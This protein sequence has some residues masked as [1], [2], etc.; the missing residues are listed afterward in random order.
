MD[1]AA[2]EQLAK[3]LSAMSLREAQ[4]ELRQLDPEAEMKFWRNAVRNEQHTLWVL[5]Q[6]GVAVTLVERESLSPSDRE[7]GGGPRGTKAQRTSYEYV[8]AR[9]APLTRPPHKRG[10]HGPSP[11]KR[12]EAAQTVARTC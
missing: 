3:R 2:R 6:Q 7:I 11:L 9:V 4:R 1:E 8:E 10:A 12:L 5:P